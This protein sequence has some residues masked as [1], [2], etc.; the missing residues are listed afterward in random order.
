MQD[1]AKT[2]A[3]LSEELTALRG[4]L[5]AVEAALRVSEERYRQAVENSPDPIFS[6]NA[7][8]IIQTWNRACESVFGYR[9][10]IIGQTYHGLLYNLESAP[11]FDAMVAQVFQGHMFSDL[12]MTYTCQDRTVRF[13]VSRLYPLLDRE[14]R[15]SACVFSNTDITKRVRAETALREWESLLHSIFEHVTI[16]LYRTTPDGDILMANPALVR[17]LGYDSFEELAQRNLEQEGYV[18]GYPRS[19]FKKRIESDGRVIGLESAWVRRDGSTIF[20]RESATAVRDEA[21]NTL[22]YE[23]AAEDI[24]ERKQAEKALRESEER[25]RT[26]ANFAHDWEYWLGPDGNFLFNSPSCERITGYCPDEFAENP[27]LLIDIVHPE[28]RAAIARLFEPD[29]LESSE[30]FFRDFRIITRNG[31]V[32][33]IGHISQPVYDINGAWRGRRASNRDITRRKRMEE[34]LKKSEQEK[35]LILRSISE[36]VA[37]LDTDLTIRWANQAAEASVGATRDG[38]VGRHC[39]EVWHGRSEP[40]EDCPVVTS[41]Q[42]SSHQEAEVTTADGRVWLLKSDPVWDEDGTSIVGVVQVGMDITARTQAE[43]ALRASEERLRSLVES[44]EDLIFLY[45]LD[46]RI[47]YYN[48]P[49]RYGVEPADVIGKTVFDFFD[50]ETATRLVEQIRQTADTGQSMTVE[51]HVIWRGQALW[52][53]DHIYLVKDEAGNVTS[54]ARIS[55]NIT[56]RKQ[57][58]EAL[59]RRSRD[60]NLLN[61]AGQALTA[62]FDLEQVLARLLQAVTEV[63]GA[64]GGS[65]WLWDEARAGYLVCKAAYHEGVAQTLVGLTLA[66]GEGIAGWAAQQ[67]KSALSPNVRQD[68]RFAA[69][70]DAQTGYHTENLLAVPL[71]TRDRVLGVL[72]AVNGDFDDDGVAVIET[73]AASAAIAIHNAQLVE[74]QRRYTRELEASNEELDAYAQTVAHDLRNPL[75]IILGHAQVLEEAF[76][77]GYDDPA[78]RESL[79]KSLQTISRHSARMSNIIDELLLLASVRKEEVVELLPLDMAGIVSEAQERLAYLIE[80]RQVELVVLNLEAWPTAVGYS[81][82]V[83]EVWANYLSNAIQ[84]GGQPPQVVLGAAP[85]PNETVRFWVR[86]NGPGLTPEEQGRLFTPFTRLDQARARGHGLG[87]SIVRRIVEKLGGQVGVESKVG[88]GSTFYFTLPAYDPA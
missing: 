3:Q 19:V 10:D 32:R 47:V 70:I 88:K 83:V 37:Y 53:L 54:V 36:M 87:L 81:P 50:H 46:G 52:L 28:D 68:S 15:V 76:E 60:L 9:K 30:T 61:R 79:R 85:Q 27:Q 8:G 34:A 57:V 59:Q 1:E 43:A 65:V 41:Y 71:R 66:P 33:W 82:W 42:T 12:E 20:V 39:Y 49:R 74:E 24:T 16:G 69:H 77:L 23:G 55:R 13:T 64:E 80:E 48:G 45:D 26:I 4:R 56:E 6:V 75:G 51:N 73:L 44:T 18:P 29:Q 14:G 72:E 31:D 62:T 2:E 35:A 5:M 63:I 40:C 11:A 21:G 17:M 86:D 7:D 84:Y 78:W 58:E 22:Y 25:F 38:L 67:G